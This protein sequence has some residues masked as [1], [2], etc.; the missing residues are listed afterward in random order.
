MTATT[1]S[2]LVRQS[3]IF[4]LSF[5]VDINPLRN[6]RRRRLRGELRLPKTCYYFFLMGSPG[7]GTECE[8]TGILFSTLLSQTLGG[9]SYRK[10]TPLVARTVVRKGG[11][12]WDNKLSWSVWRNYR[13]TC[14][15]WLAVLLTLRGFRFRFASLWEALW[16][17]IMVNVANWNAIEFHWSTLNIYFGHGLM[18]NI[19][20]FFSRLDYNFNSK[21]YKLIELTKKIEHT[22]EV[23]I[24][25]QKCVRPPTW[26]ISNWLSKS[27]QKKRTRFQLSTGLMRQFV[28]EQCLRF[29]RKR[30]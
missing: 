22:W 7:V 9:L 24:I 5:E 15:H 27:W 25:L 13:L 10:L 19:F 1:G 6:A 8:P 23:S 3:T 20:G 16:I 18:N 30:K 4:F 29:L 2:Q 26:L 14:T 11:G 12:V 21:R 28:P 17:A